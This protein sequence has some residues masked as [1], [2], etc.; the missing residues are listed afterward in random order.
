MSVGH[1]MSKHKRR[2]VVYNL[3]EP[4]KEWARRTA[5]QYVLLCTSKRLIVFGQCCY[6]Y[7]VVFTWKRVEQWSFSLSLA[8]AP[9][10]HFYRCVSSIHNQQHTLSVCC[11]YFFLLWKHVRHHNIFISRIAMWMNWTSLFVCV[12]QRTATKQPNKFLYQP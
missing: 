4:T 6:T 1:N 8:F 7:Y 11:V 2:C 12:T 10:T 9:A 5:L 3:N